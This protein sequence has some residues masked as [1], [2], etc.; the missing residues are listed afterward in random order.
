[1]D[2]LFGTSSDSDDM[3]FLPIAEPKKPITKTKKRK[4][5]EAGDTD[6]PDVSEDGGWGEYKRGFKKAFN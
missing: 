2:A 3:D 4:F 5:I 6:G 1:M